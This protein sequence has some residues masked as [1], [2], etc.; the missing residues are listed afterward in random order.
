MSTCEEIVDKALEDYK[1]NRTITATTWLNILVSLA[2]IVS[3][4]IYSSSKYVKGEIQN[5]SRYAFL[6]FL[7]FVFVINLFLS[8]FFLSISDDERQSDLL[9][10]TQAFA[11]CVLLIVLISI[12]PFFN[13]VNV[14]SFV[15]FKKKLIEILKTLGPK[16]LKNSVVH[17]LK[18][19][20]VQDIKLN[21][22]AIIVFTII[23]FA[24]LITSIHQSKK[25]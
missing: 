13:L 17:S 4:V 19:I 2:F 9:I 12:Y 16:K 20:P 1:I 7:V 24:L 15:I 22:Y 6:I 23:Y 11:L 3:F 21:T 8:S 14:Y 18:N 5:K 25:L 10:G